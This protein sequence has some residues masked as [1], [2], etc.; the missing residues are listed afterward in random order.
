MEGSKKWNKKILTEN[1]MNLLQ[2]NLMSVEFLL[3]NLLTESGLDIW[4][5]R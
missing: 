4:L 2:S 5:H 3:I 1:E